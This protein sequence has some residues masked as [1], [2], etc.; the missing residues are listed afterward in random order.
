MTIN[1]TLVEVENLLMMDSLIKRYH[2]NAYSL[3][4]VKKLEQSRRDYLAGWQEY[5]NGGDAPDETIDT[6]QPLMF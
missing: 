5:N 6:P 4:A 2:H 3:S 1:L